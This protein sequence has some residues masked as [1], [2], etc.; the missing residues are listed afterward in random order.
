MTDI[1][2]V[3]I[4]D[5]PAATQLWGK[6]LTR[7]NVSFPEEVDIVLHHVG[8]GNRSLGIRELARL[9]VRLAKDQEV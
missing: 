3:E 2:D 7:V 1:K 5:E 9:F 4:P 6:R 8:D